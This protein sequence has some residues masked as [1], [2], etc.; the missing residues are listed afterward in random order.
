MEVGEQNVTTT[1]IFF[2]LAFKIDFV[3]ILF[4]LDSFRG[5]SFIR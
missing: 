1:L 2:S 3:W 5:L 4:L